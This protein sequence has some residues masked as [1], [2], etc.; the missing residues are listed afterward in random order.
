MNLAIMYMEKV[1]VWTEIQQIQLRVKIPVHLEKLDWNFQSE[2]TGDE[3]EILAQDEYYSK[4]NWTFKVINKI[5]FQWK[6]MSWNF[7]FGIWDNNILYLRL[8]V[9][10][11]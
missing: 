11:W 7:I 6:K 2:Y 10:I 8:K 9:I 4:R 3:H 1:L 5:C